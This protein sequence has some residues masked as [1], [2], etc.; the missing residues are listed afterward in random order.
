MTKCIGCGIEL[1]D[2]DKNK[3]GYVEDINNNICTRCFKL[4]HYGEYKK[5]ELNNNDYNKIIKSISTN[6][7]VVYV[8]DFL[9]LNLSKI[10][11]FNKVLLVIT[12]R[13]IIP[14]S[15]KE[16]KIINYL[17]EKYINI[18]DI[19]IV[20][21][22]NN[23][24][25]DNLYN[26]LNKYSNNKDIYVVGYTNT[27]KSTLIN[28]LISNYTSDS[29]NV[30]TSM[31]PSTTLDKISIKLNEL[32]LIDTPGLI[33]ESN[34]INYIDKSDLK[35]ILPKKSIKP[36]TCQINGIGSILIDNYMR[37]DYDTNISNSIVIYASNNL[38]VKF[39]SLSNNK[40]KD[41]K[42]HTISIDSNKDLV[43]PGLCF[44]KIT[45]PIKVKLYIMDKVKPYLRDNLI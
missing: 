10:N 45:K 12:K 31:Y 42:E 29:I 24:N 27:G 32:T 20:S 2:K 7:L 25:I 15:V 36:K 19:I 34:I 14:E 38:N 13:D 11:N 3:L 43:I 16:Y 6:N 17:K 21:S 37:L 8:S 5:V 33:D 1:Q 39:N 22:L 35:K 41:L 44:I 9:S 26:M 18:I 40:L 4:K 30:T 28:K 23:Y